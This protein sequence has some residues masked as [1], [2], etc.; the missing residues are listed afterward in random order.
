MYAVVFTMNAMIEKRFVIPDAGKEDTRALLEY[1]VKKGFREIDFRFTDLWGK[2][3]HKT[4][5]TGWLAR[6]YEGNE[7][8]G[9]DGSSIR[10]WKEIYDS[11][12]LLSPD[13]ST[14]FIDPFYSS[15]TIAV[16]CNVYDPATGKPYELDPRSIALKAEE[17]L[18]AYIGEDS[19]AYFGPEPEFFI[20][21][22]VLVTDVEGHKV[23]K[24]FSREMPSDENVLHNAMPKGGYEP[25]IADKLQDIRSEMARTMEDLGIVI[26]CHHHEV[27]RAGQ[28]EIDP[29]YGTLTAMA[30]TLQLMRYVVHN[31]ARKHGMVATYMPKIFSDDNGS[32]MHVHQSIWKDGVPLFAGNKL[33][34]LSE[35]AIAYA[36]G[37]IEHGPSLYAFTNPTT[38]SAA[39][40]KPG[41]EAPTYLALALSNRS[42]AIRIPNYTPANPKAKRIEVRFPDPTANPYLALT[43]MLLAGIDGIRKGLQKVPIVEKK[44]MAHLS[45][46]ER[47]FIKELPASLTEAHGHLEK[48]KSWLAGI[49]SED[50]IKS[51][52]RK[53]ED[54]TRELGALK[55]APLER[56]LVKEWEMYIV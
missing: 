15:P 37:I 29:H 28:A 46:E 36:A 53:A 3:H 38:N 44:D 2:E 1:A 14:A 20:F 30:D 55:D 43:A 56:R 18:R 5:L 11:D 10:G 25:I 22:K 32:G 4:C 26:E 17:Y 9:F 8:I 12:M 31:V 52:H 40:L 41:F 54:D 45:L 6:C 49:I 39:R 23:V 24:I 47:E 50:V 42:A 33:Y 51:L 13:A 34:G 19:V 21:D 35:L 48:D 27:A 16:R 7:Y